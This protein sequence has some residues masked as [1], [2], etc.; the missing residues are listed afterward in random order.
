[1]PAGM[2]RTTH[3]GWMAGPP[4]VPPAGAGA[5]L[6]ELAAD[7][8]EAAPAAVPAWGGTF[9]AP[10]TGNEALAVVLVHWSFSLA[11]PAASAG[12]KEPASLGHT[13]E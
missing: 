4:G 7:W 8:A 3:G 13:H 10:R 2:V 12:T 6:A 11:G 1:M 9:A 5:S